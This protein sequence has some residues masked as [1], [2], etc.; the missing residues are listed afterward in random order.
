[1]REIARERR[2][3]NIERKWPQHGMKYQVTA[4]RAVWLVGHKLMFF[5][6]SLTQ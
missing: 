6:V 5:P 1:M 3:A 2:G 4:V